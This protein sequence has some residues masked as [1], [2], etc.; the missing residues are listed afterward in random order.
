MYPRTQD[1]F[2]QGAAENLYLFGEVL[3]DG[4][5]LRVVGILRSENLPLEFKRDLM[6]HL[7]GSFQEDSQ[8]VLAGL[9]VI[10]QFLVEAFQI[11]AHIGIHAPCA[12]TQ[13]F[14]F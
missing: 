14:Q 10:R 6:Y 7:L 3:R 9:F 8:G 5:N 13:A 2:Q 11:E 12:L 4:D 1:G